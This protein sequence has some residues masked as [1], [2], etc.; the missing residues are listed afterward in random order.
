MTLK[1][2]DLSPEVVANYDA[3]MARAGEKWHRIT[4]KMIPALINSGGPVSDRLRRLEE[5][6]DRANKLAAPN[7]PCKEGCSRCCY[8]AVQIVDHEAERIGKYI[9][10]KPRAIA[11]TLTPEDAIARGDEAI[12]KYRYKP[13]VFLE[14]DRCSIY[15]VRPYACRM[16]VSMEA[17]AEP[18]D[19]S[20]HSGVIS[21]LDWTIG[22]LTLVILMGEDVTKFAD[23]RDVFPHGRALPK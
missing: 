8:Q 21:Q 15:E 13:C 23:I 12:E 20:K 11:D 7:S 18:C 17:S 10:V 6:I 22:N 2:S 14:N 3:F 16:Y 9:G 4:G 5:L 19:W 1:R